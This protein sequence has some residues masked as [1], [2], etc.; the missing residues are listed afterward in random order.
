M[1]VASSTA[2]IGSSAH[3][4]IVRRVMVWMKAFDAGSLVPCAQT[5]VAHEALCRP[6]LGR[7]P[8]WRRDRRFLATRADEVILRE[9]G[10]LRMTFMLISRPTTRPR[11]QSRESRRARRASQRR[12]PRAAAD[13]VP[14]PPRACAARR[15]AS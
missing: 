9:H 8:R 2:M 5:A 13:P 14:E 7:S 11:T 15:G 3:E 12:R 10:S 4:Q 6:R 1:N